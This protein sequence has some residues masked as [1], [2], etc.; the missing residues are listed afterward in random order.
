MILPVDDATVHHILP[1][2]RKRRTYLGIGELVEF[3]FP[4]NSVSALHSDLI[5]P[6]IIFFSGLTVD[7][8]KRLAKIRFPAI[9]HRGIAVDLVEKRKD[10]FSQK[11]LGEVISSFT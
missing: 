9:R 2:I 4:E 3:S 7:L 8:E 5:Y 1:V 10:L 6:V 11:P